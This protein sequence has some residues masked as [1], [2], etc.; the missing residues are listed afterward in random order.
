L[1]QDRFPRSY[2]ELQVV[3]LLKVGMLTYAGDD[4]RDK[5][6]AYR[7]AVDLDAG[8]ARF[9]FRHPDESGHW[10]W[11]KRDTIMVLPSCLKE[12]LCNGKLMA[13]TLREE[14][15]ADGKRFAVL[16]FV[17]EVEKETLPQWENMGRVLGADWGVHSLLTATA[18][19]GNSSQAGR[20]FFLDTGGFDGRQARTR[21]QIDELKSSLRPAR[22]NLSLPR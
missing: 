1:H 17:I 4:G 7:L 18:V 2:E 13:P 16:D 10:H 6:Q 8:V 14:R 15:R 5:G 22:E 19:D 11:R 20:P 12:R 9:R 21:R 3:P